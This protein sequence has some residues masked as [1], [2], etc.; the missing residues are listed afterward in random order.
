MNGVL[1]PRQLAI[2]ACVLAVGMG[3][4][5]LVDLVRLAR[6]WRWPSTEATIVA[7]TYQL[8]HE[9]RRRRTWTKVS[10]YRADIRYSYSVGGQ[11]YTTTTI[12]AL[13]DSA[14]KY[15]AIEPLVNRF[16]PGT[17]VPVRYSP[18][19]PQVAY[20]DADLPWLSILGLALL[21]LVG[22]ALSVRSVREALFRD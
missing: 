17:A 20:L 21:P 18:A 10:Y 6:V 11:T 14:E 9:Y 3:L 7:S 8:D 22:A 13:G 2:G 16:R 12:R 1:R 4:I 5:G 15:G 19:D